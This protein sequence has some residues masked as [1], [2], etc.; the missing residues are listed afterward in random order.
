LILNVN[1]FATS[2]GAKRAPDVAAIIKERDSMRFAFFAFFSVV[3]FFLF[4]FPYLP[5]S[6]SSIRVALFNT[7]SFDGA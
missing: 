5:I 3:H 4:F 2:F 7:L 1:K 6:A